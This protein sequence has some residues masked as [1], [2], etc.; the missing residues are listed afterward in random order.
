VLWLLREK[1]TEG[2]DEK[3]RRGKAFSLQVLQ[4][5]QDGSIS[6]ELS[7]QERKK[8][9]DSSEDDSKI[10]QVQVNVNL[11]AGDKFGRKRTRRGGRRRN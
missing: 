7:R 2:R 1:K 3:T 4:M 10:S 6:Y 9:Q 11:E 5:P 8:Q